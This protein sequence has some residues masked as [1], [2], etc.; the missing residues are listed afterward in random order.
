MEPFNT[1][2]TVYS[3]LS[4]QP[5][6]DHDTIRRA[7][8]GDKDA[9]TV[10]FQKTYRRMFFVARR[11]LTNDEDIYDALQIGYTKAYKYIHRVTTPETFYAWLSKTVENA[12][13]DVRRDI[14]PSEELSLE[15]NEL[16]APDTAEDSDRRVTLRRVLREMDPRRA[17]VLALYYYD[18]LKLSEISRLLGEP[19][20]TVHSRLT[21]AKRELTDLLAQR[22]ID[23]SFYGGSLLSAIAISLRSVLGTDIL[24]AAVAQKML[25]EILDGK[26]GRLEMAAC[27]MVEQHRN[28]AILRITSLLM[29]LVVAVALLTTAVANGWFFGKSR[30]AVVVPGETTTTVGNNNLATTLPDETTVTTLP[31][32]TASPSS[33]TTADG[34]TTL[35]GAGNTTAPTVRTTKTTYPTSG[36]KTTT[37]TTASAATT[38][39]DGFASDYRAGRANTVGNTVSNLLYWNNFGYVAMQDQWLYYSSGTNHIHLMKKP[40]NGGNSQLLFS[41]NDMIHN[42]NV[43]G[44][45]IYYLDGWSGI[46]RIRTDG[47]HRELLSTQG[48]FALRVIGDTCYFAVE[49]VSGKGEMTLYRMDIA[50]RSAEAFYQAE[51]INTVSVAFTEEEALYCQGGIL[52]IVSYTGSSRYI[53]L[54][55][56]QL[57]AVE[58]STVYATTP[59]G[60]AY[61]NI[62]ALDYTRSTTPQDVLIGLPYHTSVFFYHPADGGYF[63]NEQRSDDN[64]RY[65]ATR[66]DGSSYNWAYDTSVGCYVFDDDYVYFFNSQYELCRAKPSGTGYTVL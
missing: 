4:E 63:G 14:R 13:R 21:A 1:D 2:L 65:V 55:F 58:G 22:G 57:A 25:D 12:A 16:P 17:E 56:S 7:A 39:G 35:Y 64:I 15:V 43:V 41:G 18:G 40:K 59:V 60:S 11:I 24:S 30:P 42:I 28:K 54:N 51:G 3:A 52:Y 9:F 49:G 38:A 32:T 61:T 46:Y 34:V 10:L 20:S 62:V 5:E 19:I 66:F 48:A 26:S 29:T 31:D 8:E 23:R 44:D 6:L 50:T 53:D 47:E 36:I 33:L 45:W 37:A 27:K